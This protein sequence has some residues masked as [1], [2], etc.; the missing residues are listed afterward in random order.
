MK[1]SFLLILILSSVQLFA[2]SGLKN[3]IDALLINEVPDESGPGMTV[4][5]VKG[6]QVLYHSSRGR[7][8]LEYNLPFNDSTVIGLA[9]VTKQF[10]AACIGILVKQ[11]KLSVADDVRKYIPELAFYGDTIRIQ[12]LLNHT[13]GIRNHNVLL[14]LKG[15]DYKHQGYTNIMIQD[16]MFRQKG[17]N[18]APGEKM[19]Y[20][21]TNYVL[22]ALIVERIAG[23]EL[24][25]FSK[26]ELFVPMEMDHTFFIHDLE[27]IIPN[28]AY[29]YYLSDKGY[30]QP[31]SL[32]LCVG[33]GGMESTIS[34]LI[35]WSEI[36]L[37]P[38]H[39]FSYLKDFITELDTLDNGEA[40]KYGRGMF[41]APYKQHGTIN[42]SGR[43][44]G[45]RS[46]FICVPDLNLGVMVYTNNENINAVNTSYK[47]LDL[48]ISEES[49]TRYKTA[50]YNHSAEELEAF[51]GTFQELNSDL[52]MGVFLENDT[53]KA[54][55]SMGSQ[56]TSLISEGR[57]MFSRIDNPY[58]KYAYLKEGSGYDFQVD[59]GGAIF[60]FEK[61]KL[62]ENPN[63]N[64][65][66]YAGNFYSKELDATYALEVIGRQL[67]LKY[68]NHYLV[69]KEGQK[70][71]FGANRRTK[72][73]FQR[74]N[75][76][77]IISFEVASE[78][79]VKNILFEK[80]N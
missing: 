56:A 51:T 41:V 80:V 66:D 28:R 1:F 45:M 75:D 61:I 17:I 48:F 63:Q 58:I 20:S 46:Q 7:M 9:S 59:F 53:L 13:S 23:Y 8:N 39:Q 10:T 33:A 79:T 19:L 65:E 54:V 5:V 14:D 2:Q 55:S 12:H 32:T 38:E 62:E 71:V 31:K 43:D 42:H 76:K 40:L 6:G 29:P 22:L 74:Q 30:R 49:E 52:R 68:P 16:L 27:A 18:N 4:G 3:S 37:N 47:I 60:Y 64:L 69:L 21:N 78:G 70:G 72:Y 35:K 50:A 25:E 24:H 11:G 77:E 67:V 15:F 44:L 26:N 34:D 73:I 36:F 57:N